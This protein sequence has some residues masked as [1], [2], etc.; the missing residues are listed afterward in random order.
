LEA[1][2]AAIVL[3]LREGPPAGVQLRPNL[4]AALAACW[5]GKFHVDQ[6]GRLCASLQMPWSG[7][8]RETCILNLQF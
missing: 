8:G 5:F 1:L 2:L 4:N 7:A 3:R 6:P